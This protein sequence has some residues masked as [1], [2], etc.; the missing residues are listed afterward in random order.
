M[1]V[2]ATWTC[3]DCGRTFGAVGRNHICAPGR[4]V[5]AFLADSPDFVR[6]VFEAVHDHLV[7][8]DRE[9]G[10]DLIVD[11]ISSKVLFKHGP[12]FC[13]VE[14]RKQW[15][16]V[17]FTLRRRLDGR[18]MSRAIQEY[19][20]K[21]HHVVNVVD[22]ATIDDEFREWLTE[23]YHHGVAVG[24]VARPSRGDPMVP[25]DVDVEIAP[26]P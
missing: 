4:S 22:A 25:D 8:V 21:Y 6:P 10:G 16:T 26:P 5:E 18:R 19:G 7:A 24:D 3:P 13:V 15:V 20:D 23:A 2:M 1:P 11:P 9:V 17:G 12:T 14:P